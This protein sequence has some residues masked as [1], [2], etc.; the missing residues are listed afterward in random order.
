[1]VVPLIPVVAGTVARTVAPKVAQKVAPSMANNFGMVPARIKQKSFLEY[2]GKAFNDKFH[3]NPKGL[4]KYVS[5][6]KS[7]PHQAMR[8]FITDYKMDK[9]FGENLKE[10]GQNVL[11]DIP[12]GEKS[13]F[14]N[15]EQ[16]KK[17]VIK[18]PS[19]FFNNVGNLGTTIRDGKIVGSIPLILFVILFI[20]FAIRP[21]GN[22]KE[23]R[24]TLMFK[25]ILGMTELTDEFDDLDD[26]QKDGINDIRNVEGWAKKLTT[27]LVPQ[28]SIPAKQLIGIGANFSEK[29]Y[30]DLTDNNS[31]NMDGLYNAGGRGYGGMNR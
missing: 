24:L 14:F 30:I 5:K 6:V 26:D 29:I 25:S 17:K 7:N 4:K 12:E 31:V 19:R 22:S 13:P 10:I 15:G 11:F 8:N 28:Y 2:Y 16:E 1:M 23:T 21:V 3:F 18:T 9:S 20:V 27:N